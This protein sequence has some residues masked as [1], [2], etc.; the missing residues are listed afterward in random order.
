[1]GSFGLLDWVAGST[2]PVVE[3]VLSTFGVLVAFGGSVTIVVISVVTVAAAI[4]GFVINAV[5]L[6]VV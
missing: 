2:R 3:S 4:V 5:T 1:M 6:G